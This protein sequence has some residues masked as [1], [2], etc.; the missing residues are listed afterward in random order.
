MDR[1]GHRG[2]SYPDRAEMCIRDSP[3]DNVTVHDRRLGQNDI[4]WRFNMTLI[5]RAVDTDAGVALQPA[6][7]SLSL[8]HI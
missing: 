7:K 4:G 3:G 1:G 6:A 5:D 8:I 2:G